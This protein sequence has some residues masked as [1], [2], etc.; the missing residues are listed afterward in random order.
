MN[1]LVIYAHPH[2]ESLNGAFLRKTLEGLGAHPGHPEVR[3]LD[4]HERGF[5][6]VLVYGPDQRRRDLHLVPEL[7]EYRDLILWADHLVF[8]YPIYWGR[9]PALVLGFIDRLFASNFAYR[10]HPG[11]LLPEGLLAGKR[12][13]CISTMKGPSGYLRLWLG[14]AHRVLMG[15]AVFGLVGIRKVKFFEFG[16]MEAPSGRQAKALTRIEA[17]F[18]NLRPV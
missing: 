2:R 18:R 5:D 13:T 17:Y 10:Y 8:V 3:V 6:P 16:A 11:R 4:L 9:P 15:R 14:N 1:T 12:V 7:A